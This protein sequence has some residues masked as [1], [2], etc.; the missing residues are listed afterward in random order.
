MLLV[1]TWAAQTQDHRSKSERQTLKNAK[2]REKFEC[3]ICLGKRLY[4]AQ[5][6]QPEKAYFW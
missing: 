3:P 5:P 1:I 2:Q 4:P 6:S